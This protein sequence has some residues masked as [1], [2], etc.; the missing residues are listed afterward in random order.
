MESI[1]T[2]TDLKA[3]LKG[4]PRTLALICIVQACV[5]F[6]GTFIGHGGAECQ[7]DVT[8]TGVVLVDCAACRAL[9]GFRWRDLILLLGGLG[10]IGV[11]FYAALLR[12]QSACQLYGMVML[13]YG[14]VIGLTAILTG[15][16]C[17][18]ISAAASEV[19]DNEA[20]EKIAFMMADNVRYHSI[21]YGTYT[22]VHARR[23]IPSHLASSS[24]SQASIVFS[25]VSAPSTRFNRS[26]ISTSRR[27]NGVT[28]AYVKVKFSD[29]GL[30]ARVTKFIKISKPV[31]SRKVINFNL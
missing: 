25:T 1:T 3:D 16:Q 29:S 2:I 20:C 19:V 27:R 28:N 4:A 7:L 17:P 26:S 11:G 23:A 18:V 12:N 6:F 21:F 24:S 31:Y 15:L 10:I 22:L 13:F 30:A 8:D 5:L 9:G 14:F